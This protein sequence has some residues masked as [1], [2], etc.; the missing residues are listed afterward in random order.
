MMAFREPAIAKR[1]YP[2]SRTNL[3][4]RESVRRER[5]FFKSCD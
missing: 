4:L 1:N 3:A 2:Q 5:A